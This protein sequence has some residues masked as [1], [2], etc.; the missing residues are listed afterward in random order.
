MREGWDDTCAEVLAKAKRLRRAYARRPT[1]ETWELYRE[2]RNQ[3]TRVIR[4]ALRQAHRDQV[5]MAAASPESLWRIAKWARNRENQPPNVTP[6]IKYPTLN[7]EAVL[8]EEKIALLKETFFPRPPEVD[9]SDIENARYGDQIPMPDITEK[10][11]L[12]AIKA[13]APFK[14]PGPDGIP[15]KILQV[16]S[17]LLVAH[18][19]MIMNQSLRL[20]YCPAHFRNCTT[21]VLRKPGKDN[22]NIP[23]AYRP[24]ALLNTIS[25]VMD[26]IIARRLSYLV[27]THLVLPRM[28]IGGRKLKSTKHALYAVVERIYRAWNTGQGQ[29]LS[30]LLLNVF[31]AFDNVSHKRLLHNLRKQKVDERIVRW[32]TSFLSN[33]RTRISIDGYESAEYQIG[34]RV[35]Q[36]SP[37]SPD[38]YILYN[39]DLIE[40]CDSGDTQ[41][42]GYIDDAAIFACGDTTEETCSRLKQALEKANQ[43]VMTHAS[44]F[45]PDKFQLTHFTWA[46]T[47]IDVKR[48]LET[49]WGKITPKETCKYLGVTLDRKLKWREHVQ[50]IRRKTTKTV[51]ALSCLGS[52]T[53]SVRLADMR[54]IYRG[55]AVPQM[56]YACSLWSNPGESKGTCTRTTLDI[57]K[58][59]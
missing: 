46:N 13:A 49:S 36:C 59:I 2:A 58:V 31:S 53:W 20:G 18:L 11:V 6:I 54:K 17:H 29:V 15:N 39:S 44:K 7:K 35:P 56:M 43:W 52:S 38:L 21:V 30:L 27:E 51:N 47:R 26:A 37:L 4:K 12:D 22:Y 3:K 23:K 16:A 25:K 40:S 8:P 1:D 9:L 19:L 32:I 14:A 28:H 33:R 45:S 48:P 5:E 10:E 55:G 24:I 42:T 50:E 57:L 41:A 34:T